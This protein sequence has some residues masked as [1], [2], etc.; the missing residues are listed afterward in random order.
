MCGAE[1]PLA[2]LDKLK[3]IGTMLF[4]HLKR[5]LKLDRLRLQITTLRASFCVSPP[6]YRAGF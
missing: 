2:V 5:I 3:R 4:A 6:R 1:N